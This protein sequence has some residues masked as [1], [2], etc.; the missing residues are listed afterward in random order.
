MARVNL[1]DILSG[2]LSAETLNLV[3]AEIETALDR[4]VFRDGEAP[5][6][7]QADLD[8]GGNSILN[9]TSDPSDPTSIPTW[10]DISGYLDDRATGYVVQ[11]IELQ[12]ATASQS[13]FNLTT[14]TFLK[15]AN[16]LAVY[17]NGVRKFTPTD[18]TETDND[19]VTFGAGLSNGDK[20]QFVSNEYLA[21]VSLPSHNHPWS[22]ILGV[23]E[24]A[25]RWPVWDEVDDK[26]LTFAPSAHNHDASNINSG[27]LADARRGVHVQSTQ[28]TATTVGELWFF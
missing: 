12:T 24:Y 18:Y 1:Q 2:Y 13:V 25:S 28:P 14:M 27:R 11:R 16:N 10:G 5:N 22:N 4:A 19:T 15:G 17:V 23:P 8:M 9:I 21:T 7:M 6:A 20:V 3:L 26:P